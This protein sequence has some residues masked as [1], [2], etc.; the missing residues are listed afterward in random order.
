MFLALFG[1]GD[2]GNQIR[3][4]KLRSQPRGAAAAARSTV[5]A[6]LAR[7]AASMAKDVAMW[8]QAPARSSSSSQRFRKISMC[9]ALYG[10]VAGTGVLDL[11]DE[12]N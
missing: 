7:E 1:R 12:E 11:T 10:G 5:A 9:G 8:R 2:D 6:G 3:F 4:F